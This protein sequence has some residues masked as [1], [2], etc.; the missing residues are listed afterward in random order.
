V[1]A[2]SVKLIAP[3]AIKQGYGKRRAPFQLGHCIRRTAACLVFLDGIRDI[4]CG[5]VGSGSASR[6]PYSDVVRSAVHEVFG[7]VTMEELRRWGYTRPIYNHAIFF[8]TKFTQMH[9]CFHT[10]Q[11][12]SVLRGDMVIKGLLSLPV[13]N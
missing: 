9:G 8:D 12:R 11:A 3:E 4:R 6:F 7:F 2:K 10:V 5:V 13:L 1:P